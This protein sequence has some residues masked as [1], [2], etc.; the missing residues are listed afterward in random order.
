[1]KPSLASWF[2]YLDSQKARDTYADF[3]KL[4]LSHKDL[5]TNPCQSCIAGLTIFAGHLDPKRLLPRVAL[6]CHTQRRRRSLHH[7]YVHN[8]GR[9][10]AWSRARLDWLIQDII[11]LT[12]AG[13]KRSKGGGET[14]KTFFRSGNGARERERQRQTERERRR[15]LDLH[16][17]LLCVPSL[18]CEVFPPWL[19]LLEGAPFQDCS[20]QS[21]LWL[22]HAVSDHTHIHIYL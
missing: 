15:G 12:H 20:K 6:G 4:T 10:P 5:L 3:L 13:I 2:N 1:M 9:R 17:L 19:C 21:A 14:G 16:S 22:T 18:H 7:D 11:V 8:L